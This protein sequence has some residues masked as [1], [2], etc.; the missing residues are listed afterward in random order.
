MAEE[1]AKMPTEEQLKAAFDKAAANPSMAAQAMGMVNM[2]YAFQFA[3]H[4][5]PKSEIVP[6]ENVNENLNRLHAVKALIIS[7]SALP[8][9]TPK[10]MVLISYYAPEG[11]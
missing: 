7:V 6:L 2:A 8:L 9:A 5:V 4:A 11:I 1:E 3:Q 10:M